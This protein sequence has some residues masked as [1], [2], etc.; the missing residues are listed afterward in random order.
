MDLVRLACVK[1]AASVHPEPGSNS[2]TRTWP[3][4]AP[5]EVVA[6]VGD[7]CQRAHHPSRESSCG[8]CV[9]AVWPSRGTNPE[10]AG[11]H[12]CCRQGR[13]QQ[14]LTDSS[15]STRGW[16]RTARTGV[17]SSLPF[18]RSRSSGTHQQ[19]WGSVRVSDVRRWCRVAFPEGIPFREAELED[20]SSGGGCNTP[21]EIISTRWCDFLPLRR[22]RYLPCTRSWSLSWADSSSWAPFA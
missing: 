9:L 11:N 6:R 15:S 2:P 4:L 17:L 14:K 10:T 16:R 5:T 12:G 18:S 22:S 3:R 19:R 21:Q 13:R 8:R 20:S 1:H 7:E